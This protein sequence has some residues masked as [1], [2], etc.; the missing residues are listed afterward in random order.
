MDSST[1]FHLQIAIYKKFNEADLATQISDSG[2]ICSEV[3]G[4]LKEI[5]HGSINRLQNLK[6]LSQY[7]DKSCI[8]KYEKT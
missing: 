3:G 4:S 5:R 2:Q 6:I 1:L 7:Q 8:L